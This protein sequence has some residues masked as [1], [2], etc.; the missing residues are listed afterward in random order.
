MNI[1][2]DKYR[3]ILENLHEGILIFD[4]N[5]KVRVYLPYG[6]QWYEYSIRRLKENPNIARYVLKSLFS[7]RN[8]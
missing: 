2:A 7:K 6:P 5:Y 4:N 8:Y 3:T 1:N